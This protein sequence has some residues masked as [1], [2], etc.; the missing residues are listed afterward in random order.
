MFT[1][2]MGKGKDYINNKKGPGELDVSRKIIMGTM[3]SFSG[4]KLPDLSLL[5]G[6]SGRVDID[7][8]TSGTLTHEMREAD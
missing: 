5:Q 6:R 7:G 4:L 1:G 2:W 3:K 8:L